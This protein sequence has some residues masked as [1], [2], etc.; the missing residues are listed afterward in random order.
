MQKQKIADS[1]ASWALLMEGVS[2]ARLETHRIRQLLNRA[3]R[4]IDSSPR[5]EEIFQRA[6]DVIMSLPD[7]LTRL[8][9]LLDR[10]S[11]ALTLAGKEFLHSNLSLEDRTMVENA[12]E[13]V[14]ILPPINPARKKALYMKQPGD[15]AGVRTVVDESS[16]KG[17]P[18]EEFDR[19]V[20]PP[21]GPRV[22]YFSRPEMNKGKP[23]TTRIMPMPGEQYGVPWKEEVTQ[24]RTMT[25]ER[26][27]QVF[28]AKR[29]ASRY[30]GKNP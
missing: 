17:L 7:R 15:L 21:H 14:P 11:Y 10:T 16:A 29:I 5:K 9:T 28:L 4:A 2:A 26:L 22:E 18:A 25:A 6:G 27:V 24:R 12:T 13:S 23:E 19:T 8:D 3:L 1:Q 20:G 30:L